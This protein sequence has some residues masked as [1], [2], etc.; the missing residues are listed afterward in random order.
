[1][2]KVR[3]ILIKRSDLKVKLRGLVVDEIREKLDPIGVTV[4]GQIERRFDQQ[5]DEEIRWA[6]LWVNKPEAVSKFTANK[7]ATKKRADRVKRAQRALDRI[8]VAE[9]SGEEKFHTTRRKARRKLREAK[10]A[11]DEGVPDLFRRGGEALSDTGVLR[12]SFFH[13]VRETPGG[14]T[15]Q[16]GSPLPRALFHQTGFTT[17]GPNYV[18]L[19]SRARK[20]WNPKL[21]PGHD[22]IMFGKGV[23]VPARPMVRLTNQNRKDIIQIA[24]GR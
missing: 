16:I 18:P 8:D 6:E 17:T 9:R 20:G 1:M 24:Q 3:R 13:I 4:L 5:G 14:G 22:F 12:N 21:I 11:K 19:T 23:T 7:K 15:V 2:A 10:Q